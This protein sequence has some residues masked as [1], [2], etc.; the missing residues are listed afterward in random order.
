MTTVAAG[1]PADV[2]L[3]MSPDDPTVGVVKGQHPG[4]LQAVAA[5]ACRR[6]SRPSPYADPSAYARTAFIEALAEAGVTV[7]AADVGPNAVEKLPAAGLL[8]R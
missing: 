3:E 7:S 5:R 1:E 6:W 8:R 4:R 2:T